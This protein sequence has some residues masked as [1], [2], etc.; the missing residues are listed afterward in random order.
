M[1][2]STLLRRSN[3]YDFKRPKSQ[4]EAL[5]EVAQS[6]I[7]EEAIKNSPMKKQI[8]AISEADPLSEEADEYENEVISFLNKIEQDQ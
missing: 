6:Q 5:F 3:Q 8:R 4:Q 2:E 1:K 7:I